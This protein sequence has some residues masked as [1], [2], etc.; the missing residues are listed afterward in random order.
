MKHGGYGG[1]MKKKSA[2]KKS[3][4]GKKGKKKKKKKGKAPQ[5]KTEI[6][7]KKSRTIR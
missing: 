4:K 2:A 3:K 6:H 1:S 7:S 5:K